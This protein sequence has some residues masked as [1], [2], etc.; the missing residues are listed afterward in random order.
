MRIKK[1]VI[2]IAQLLK[3][4]FFFSSLCSTEREYILIAMLVIM[5]IHVFVH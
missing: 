2:F 1:T 4:I 3:D 5:W